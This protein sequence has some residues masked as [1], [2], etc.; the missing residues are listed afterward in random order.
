MRSWRRVA[1]HAG[2]A[3]S[4]LR[5]TPVPLPPLELEGSPIRLWAAAAVRLAFVA[6]VADGWAASRLL[7]GGQAPLD[8]AAAAVRTLWLR[9]TGW[10]VACL[11]RRRPP[12]HRPSPFRMTSWQNDFSA[13]LWMP[14]CFCRGH[15]ANRCLHHRRHRRRRHALMPQTRR[16]TLRRAAP[17]PLLRIQEVAQHHNL[18]RTPLTTM[19]PQRWSCRRWRCGLWP[20]SSCALPTPRSTPPSDRKSVV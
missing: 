13:L 8:G 3:V 15:A 9:R 20:L 17:S 19:P 11:P 12:E 18:L 7:V 1:A 5:D 6:T 2:R 16:G 10:T 4:R 14:L